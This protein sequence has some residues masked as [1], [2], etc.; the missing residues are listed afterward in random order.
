MVK[1]FLLRN[2]AMLLCLA[3]LITSTAKTTYGFIIVKSDPLVNNFVPTILPEE[4]GT[5]TFFIK[6]TV[7]NKNGGSVGPKDFVFKVTDVTNPEL[8]EIVAENLVTDEN[9]NVTMITVDH[10]VFFTGSTLAD[11][12]NTAYLRISCEEIN[13]DSI[14]TVNEPIV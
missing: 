12:S 14:I 7:D 4:E 2:V 1:K 6:K 10:Q 5:A 9:G 3:M 13:D 11:L 8:V